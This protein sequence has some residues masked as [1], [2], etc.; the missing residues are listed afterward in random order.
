M[1][2]GR[3]SKAV[4]ERLAAAVGGKVEGGAGS[5]PKVVFESISREDFRRWLDDHEDELRHWEY[6]PVTADS[7]RVI[8]YSFPSKVH[9]STAG[10]IMLDILK[11]VEDAGN[12]TELMKTFRMQYAPT[13]NVGDRDQEP[14]GSLTPTAADIDAFPNLIVEIAHS[15]SWNNLV[16]KLERW[17]GPNTT[18]QVAIGVKVDR[19]NRRIILLQRDGQ[20]VVRTEVDFAVGDPA[21]ISFPLRA[22]YHGVA[23]PDA[24]VGHEDDPIWIDLV[25]LRGEID[26]FP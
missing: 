4:N 8:V 21:P 25:W 20:G 3:A 24:L 23:L 5:G 14:N 12:S 22:L 6:E 1:D 7:G 16:A 10:G 19:P 2:A 18:V 15:Q 17:M 9:E 26:R 13:I 11:H